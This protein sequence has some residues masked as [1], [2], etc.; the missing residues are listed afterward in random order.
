MF[1]ALM[2]LATRMTRD[3]FLV[4]D[5]PGPERWQLVDGEAVAMAPASGIHGL[6]QAEVGALLRNHLLEAGSRCSVIVAPGVVPR[7]RQSMNHRIPDLG[8]TR[9]PPSDGYDVPEPV[10]LVEI[11]SPSNEAQTRANVWAYTTIPSLREILL[12][13]S[14]R[15]EAELLRRTS[16]GEWPAEASVIGP[17]GTLELTCMGYAAPLVAIYRTTGL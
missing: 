4:W 11:L 13:R 17:A 8:I 7:V 15:I 6:L 14:S 3:E 12:L 5:A 2:P 16:E 9:A 10:L 1:A